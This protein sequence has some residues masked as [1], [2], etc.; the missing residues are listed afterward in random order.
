[1]SAEPLLSLFENLRVD[2]R[3]D[4]HAFS[5]DM[6][7]AAELM[8]YP[9]ALDHDVEQVRRALAVTASSGRAALVELRRLLGVLRTTE[10]GTAP[11][12]GAAS[13]NGEFS[14]A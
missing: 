8:H 12:P 2:R 10:S 6:V 13:R 5:A 14:R 3:R 1:M 4:Q 11:Q 7:D 9:Y